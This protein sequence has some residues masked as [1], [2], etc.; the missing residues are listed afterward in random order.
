MRPHVSAWFG[1]RLCADVQQMP[2]LLLK[3]EPTPQ[4]AQ[5]TTHSA[6]SMGAWVM[7]D[8]ALVRPRSS[9]RQRG[10]ATQEQLGLV[11]LWLHPDIDESHCDVVLRFTTDTVAPAPLANKKKRQ[12]EGDQHLMEEDVLTKTSDQG[13]SAAPDQPAKVF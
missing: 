12:S 6:R 3:I 10:M 9:S 2:I 13:C 1:R 4:H 7:C 5:R 11:A 8:E